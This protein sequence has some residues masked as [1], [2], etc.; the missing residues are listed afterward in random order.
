[1]TEPASALRCREQLRPAVQGGEGLFRLHF[2]FSILA[3]RV[4]CTGSECKK[5]LAAGARWN[6]RPCVRSCR[7]HR[8]ATSCCRR[9]LQYP[10]TTTPT[11][12]VAQ[13]MSQQ[14]NEGH[15]QS[16]QRW[17]WS[18]CRH[19]PHSPHAPPTLVG[20]QGFDFEG[21]EQFWTVTGDIVSSLALC[22]VEAACET[23]LSSPLANTAVP[24]CVVRSQYRGP[25]DTEGMRAWLDC[26][27]SACRDQLHT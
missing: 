6:Q 12:T 24:H 23:I 8:N 10:G 2:L 17:S 16:R 21:N 15:D 13:N 11:M 1:M 20:S 14:A 3:E 18:Q 9:E 7:R 22:D 27:C 19:N 4:L 25:C 5:W 26:L